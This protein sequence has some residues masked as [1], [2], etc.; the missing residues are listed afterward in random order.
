M[1]TMNGL[2]L[3]KQL[4]A[5]LCAFLF[6]IYPQLDISLKIGAFLLVGNLWHLRLQMGLLGKVASIYEVLC[7][8]SHC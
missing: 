4:R 8:N 7:Q 6:K 1:K 2:G 5:I 3:K